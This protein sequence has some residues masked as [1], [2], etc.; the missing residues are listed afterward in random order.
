M[1]LAGD[2]NEDGMVYFTPEI[3]YTDEMLADEFSMEIN[4]VRLGLATFQR[5]GMIQI[6]EDIICL[7]SWEKWQATDSLAQIREQTRKRVAKHREK[8][9]LIASNVTCNVTVTECNATD[10]EEEKEIDIDIDKKKENVTCKQVVDL[11]HSICISF[12]QVRSISAARQKAIKARLS[13]YSL[14]NFKAVFQ[15]AEA[16]SF[17]KGKNERNWTA[18]FD[19]LIADKNMAKVLDG[20]YADKSGG[21]KEKLPKWYQ[22]AFE[23]GSAEME[24]IRR[25]L[26]E[27]PEANAE[28]EQLANEL[29]AFGRKDG[30]I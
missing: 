14:E 22:A 19:W 21:H 4:T 20:N 26:N 12:P 1:C 17:L 5:F 9:K 25:L 3:P 23:P 13:T 7:S 30:Y 18:T 2:T 15:N 11:Y 29:K 6:V 28:R 8:Q 10:K 27:S 24:N 16:S